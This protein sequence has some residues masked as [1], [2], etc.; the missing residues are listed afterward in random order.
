MNALGYAAYGLDLE[1]IKLLL[2]WGAS[3]TARDVD[4][5]TARERLPDRTDD[6]A[7]TWA[8][9]FKLLSPTQSV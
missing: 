8:L 9:A 4:R 5:H 6:N 3:L 1:M 7:E 2:A